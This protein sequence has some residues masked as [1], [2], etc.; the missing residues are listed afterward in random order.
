MLVW[1]GLASN[2][3]ILCREDSMSQAGVAGVTYPRQVLERGDM[4]SSEEPSRIEHSW[5]RW[6]ALM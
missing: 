5:R 2:I 1:C 6:S 3:S 4:W